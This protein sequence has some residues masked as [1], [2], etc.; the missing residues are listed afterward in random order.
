M[1]TVLNLRTKSPNISNNSILSS[2]NLLTG[3]ST[4]FENALNGV[5]V[6]FR[7]PEEQAL[8]D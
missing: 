4:G 8:E 3:L 6:E 5:C 7:G 2:V 1:C